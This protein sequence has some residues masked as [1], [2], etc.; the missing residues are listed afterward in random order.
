MYLVS[1]R[2][3]VVKIGDARFPIETGERILTEHSHKYA[4]EGFS[5]MTARV[6]FRLV[7][8]WTDADERFAVCFFERD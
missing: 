2:D 4:L 1:A 5:A 7:R 3:Q 6:G 8:H